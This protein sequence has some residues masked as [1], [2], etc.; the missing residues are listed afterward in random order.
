MITLTAKIVY[1]NNKE[2]VIDKQN[3]ISISHNIVDR[4]NIVLPSYG[5][6]SNSGK[7]NFADYRG[8]I[9][10]LAEA[11]Q[12]IA[13]LPVTI[14]LNDTLNDTRLEFSNFVTRKWAYE[15]NGRE[16][17]LEITDKLENWQDIV[18]N[19]IP[20]NTLTK[21][22]VTGEEIYNTWLSKTPAEFKLKLFS[23]LDEYTRTI[24]S[25]LKVPIF[26]SKDTTLWSAWTTLCEAVGAHMFINNKGETIFICRN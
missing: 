17:S 22:N 11:K 2:I 18:V 26:I 6:I 4:G 9:R 23:E 10:R 7:I 24:L 3:L 14:Y 13:N 19:V 16:V 8:E 12:L 21:E 20:Y 15:P 5:I 25:N 1:S